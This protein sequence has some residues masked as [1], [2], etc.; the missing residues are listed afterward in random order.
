[1]SEGNGNNPGG[2]TSKAHSPVPNEE[3][4]TSGKMAKLKIFRE[5]ITLMPD[6][7]KRVA[8]RQVSGAGCQVS[9]VSRDQAL[10]PDT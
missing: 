2:V 1:M 6:M 7:R 3:L 5:L 10:T 4:G 8:R 9:A